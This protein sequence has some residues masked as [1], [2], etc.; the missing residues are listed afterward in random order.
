MEAMQA[1]TIDVVQR[2]K[3]ITQVMKTPEDV[4]ESQ[5]VT[6]ENIEGIV[7]SMPILP[8]P[9]HSLYRQEGQ[10]SVVNYVP[11]C[12]YVQQLDNNLLAI[13]QICWMSYKSMWN[14]LTWQ[15]VRFI[16]E[17]NV[18]L[19]CLFCLS[20]WITFNTYTNY[21]NRSTFYWWV[22]SSTG[23]LKNSH[24]GIR[25]KAAEVVSTIVQ[26]NPKSQQLVMESN[27]LEPLLTN[28]KSDPS[29]NARTKALGAISCKD[30]VLL[31]ISI[32]RC[33]ICAVYCAYYPL[34]LMLT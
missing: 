14:P 1:N 25:A 6:P 30:Y 10:S 34:L 33:Q 15:M 21:P 28:F 27:G 12:L 7:W 23:Y 17:I 16:A 18:F 3:E 19:V 2:M 29:T 11:L 24:A 26:N 4:L 8:E 31:C 13:F 32:I 5:G 22:G 20:F 9:I